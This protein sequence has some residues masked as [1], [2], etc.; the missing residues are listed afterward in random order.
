MLGVFEFGITLFADGSG[1]SFP[2]MQW[3]NF[4]LECSEWVDEPISVIVTKEC[5]QCH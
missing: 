4:C 1:P 3:E 5:N 2:A